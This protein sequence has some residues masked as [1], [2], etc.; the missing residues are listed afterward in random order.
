[1]SQIQ[2]TRTQIQ[3]YLQ[4]GPRSRDTL[5][6]KFAD[7]CSLEELEEALGEIDWY[8]QAEKAAGIILDSKLSSPRH[9]R[10]TLFIAGFSPEEI[11]HALTRQDWS[12]RIAQRAKRFTAD[13]VSKEELRRNLIAG[14]FDDALI[15]R[16][17]ER[18]DGEFWNEQALKA[19]VSAFQNWDPITPLSWRD[20]LRE[21][22]FTPEEIAFAEVYMRT[23][24]TDAARRRAQTMYMEGAVLAAIEELL[25]LEGFP[26]AAASEGA[27]QIERE[28]STVAERRVQ[29]YLARHALSRDDL[30]TYLR[31]L[32]PRDVD[33]AF[34]RF[35]I[36]SVDWVKAAQKPISAIAE[37][38]EGTPAALKKKLAEL[39]YTQ[40]QTEAAFSQLRKNWMP[41]AMETARNEIF[42]RHVI[43]EE[44]LCA[45]LHEQGFGG[46]DIDMAAAAARILPIYPDNDLLVKARCAYLS[47]KTREDTARRLGLS[48]EDAQLL[49]EDLDW[50]G[51][52]L[53]QYLGR[54]ARLHGDRLTPAELMRMPGRGY[55]E[56]HVVQA[57]AELDYDW[58]AACRHIADACRRSGFSDQ[59]LRSRLQAEKFP[60]AV[61]AEVLSPAE[62]AA[63]STEAAGHIEQMLEATP[64]SKAAILD[65]LTTMGFSE[66]EVTEAASEGVLDDVNWAERARVWIEEIAV[67]S[68]FS[69]R[70][71]QA[72]LEKAGFE[73]NDAQTAISQAALNETAQA[74]RR[75]GRLVMRGMQAEDLPLELTKAGFSQEAVQAA[76]PRR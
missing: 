19:A 65:E 21:Q 71:L 38:W 42:E 62:S 29:S 1:M 6:R 67:P 27:A 18:H 43:S 10:E 60:E 8:E 64:F 24:E 66:K 55:D 39:G 2:E 30:M 54:I 40:E 20:T 51:K 56:E 11:T 46:R 3:E 59:Q 69:F 35:G 58:S 47:G 37:R 33:K 32:A 63:G 23:K 45:C 52:P 53:R 17:L 48:E 41:A 70:E 44:A 26:P 76:L 68:G 31:T 75:A 72:E 34:R 25:I 4:D 12:G 49:L 13:P 28:G 16:E 57:A 61:I 15:R 14:D 36:A 73:K 9:L 74:R 5:R 50:A 7:T 22:G